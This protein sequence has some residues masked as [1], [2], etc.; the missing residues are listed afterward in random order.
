MSTFF[1]IFNHPLTPEQEADARRSPGI[2]KIAPL[3]DR[4][5]KRCDQQV[6]E[7]DVG[8]EL[9]SRTFSDRCLS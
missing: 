5:K 1:P 9:F 6:R 8:S 4:I 7:R 2:K 3:A